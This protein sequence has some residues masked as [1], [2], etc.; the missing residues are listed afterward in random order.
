MSN[1]N[2]E[3]TEYNKNY[4]LKRNTLPKH[5]AKQLLFILT[6]NNVK[7]V[8]DVGSGTGRL[9]DYLNKHKIAAF[10]CDISDEAIKISGHLKAAADKLP[11]R[12][13]TFDALL[14][15]S[16]IEHLTKKEAHG[17]IKEACRVL[18]KNGVIFLVTPNWDSPIRI[19]LGKRWFGYADPTHI[20]FYNKKELIDLLKKYDFSSFQ[21]T[22]PLAPHLDCD[23]PIPFLRRNLPK[24]LTLVINY[25]LIS[26][27]MANFRD[28]IWLLAKKQ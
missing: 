9:V 19:I 13:G 3:A 4:F 22:F 16:L 12:D 5:M 2:K 26:S 21:T 11:F 20:C 15:I 23:W 27:L 10:G 18:K 24:K 8:L 6:N 17:F 1:I 28:S 25:L 7:K 14:A